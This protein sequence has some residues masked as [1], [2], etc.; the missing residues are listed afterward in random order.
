VRERDVR[1]I[2]DGNGTGCVCE[3]SHSF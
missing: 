1:I 3:I 2:A